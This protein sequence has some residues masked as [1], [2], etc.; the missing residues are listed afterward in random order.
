MSLKLLN[1]PCFNDKV[2]HLFGRVH[3]PVAPKC[4]MQCNFC[5]R[6]YDCVNESRPGVTSMVLKPY[7][8]ICF[9]EKITE[10]RSDISVVGIAGP[11][12]PFANPEETM[13]T[14]RLVRK[15][16]PDMLLC[17]AT[18]GLNILPYI[19][20]LSKLKVSHVTITI[21]AVNPEISKKIYSWIYYNKKVLSA[22]EGTVILLA[23]QLEAVKKLK[24][25]GIA[26]KINTIIIPGIN[27]E[28]IPA[29]AKKI[30][31]YNADILNCIPLYP[32]KNTVFANINE[33]SMKMV[34]QI[35]KQASKYI[36]QM[37]HCARCRADAVGLLK[38]RINM[39]SLSKSN[40]TI[41]KE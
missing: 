33:P 17:L 41:Q 25:K 29:V 16:Y 13:E 2:R 24:N 34:K 6:K 8:A 9:L 40:Q 7:Q 19:D 10:K 31:E 14:L 38:E 26:V 32:V 3:L 21:N 30:S 27:N 11:G 4:N 23:K 28:H 12:D 15:K 18:N 20:E 36:T 5:D 37:Y 35:R 22:E 1:H 39:S